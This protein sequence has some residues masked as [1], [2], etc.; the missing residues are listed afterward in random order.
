MTF[1]CNED[2]FLEESPLDGIFA[3]NLYTTYDGFENGLNALYALVRQDRTS[4]SK[5]NSTYAALWQM[6]TDNAFVNDNTNNSAPFNNYNDLNSENVLVES[7]FN[8]LYQIVNSANMIINRAEDSSVDWM[9]TTDAANEIKKNTVIAQARLIRAW[10][11]RHL[12]YGWGAVPLSLDEI[13]GTTYRDDWNRTSVDSINI[14]MEKDLLFAKN[15]LDF[16]EETGEVNSAVASTMLSELYIEEER[17]TEA[18]SEATTLINDGPYQLMT[19]RFGVNASEPGCPF[20]DIFDNPT[21]GDGNKEV[22]WVLNDAY[23]DVTG[24]DGIWVKNEWQNHYDK[25]NKHL[26]AD[27][28]FT[29]N[30]GKGSSRAAITDSA[31]NWYESF[32]DRYSEYCVKK[33]YIYPTDASLETFDT[34]FYSS[35]EYTDLSDL[36]NNY[37]W[38]VVRKWEY[39]DPVV[40]ANASNAN[41]YDDQMF[42][43]LAETYLLAGEA[44][45]RDGKPDEAAYYFNKVRERSNAS[46]ITGDQI[47]LDFVLEERSRELMTEEYRR[48]TLARTGTFYERCIKY[49]PLLNASTV[50]TYNN[51]LPIPQGIIDSNT[52]AVM[53]Q[54][55]G[56]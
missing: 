26:D 53:E 2:E 8:W 37:T 17:Y 6:G 4:V 54:N 12:K 36:E 20:S 1:S 11:Y 21:P 23:L 33:Y 18:A 42:M 10:A 30:G 28:L 31:F 19:E 34:V 40:Y 43:R 45:W 29:Y 35:M 38:P 39:N 44:L 51:Y 47:D 48:H 55:P 13:T 7:G 15:N 5:N 16:I 46:S 24:S 3:E 9:A 41:E 22:L 56:Y 27:T 52:G 25:V 50:N 14:Q 49:N 32:D